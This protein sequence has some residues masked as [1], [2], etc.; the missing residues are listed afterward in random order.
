MDFLQTEGLSWRGGAVIAWSGMRGVVTLA[1]AQSLPSDLPYRPQLVL[2][3]FTVAIVTLVAQGASLPR[4]IDRLDVQGSDEQAERVKLA[5]L[6]TEINSA[7]LATLNNPELDDARAE[8]AH[9]S[10]VIDRAQAILD[11]EQSRLDIH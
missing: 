7:G 2:V 8:G 6:V 3:A 4:V 11:V 10:H 1:A 9:A 5:P